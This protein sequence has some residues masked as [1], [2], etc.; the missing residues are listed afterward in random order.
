MPVSPTPTPLPVSPTPTPLLLHGQAS[1]SDINAA[2]KSIA[3]LLHNM[4]LFM[5][6]GTDTAGNPIYELDRPATRIEALAIIIRL[7]GLESAANAYEGANPFTD[8][9]DWADRIAAYAYANGITVGVN[10][11][12]TLFN[13]DA[14]ISYQEFTAFLLRVLGYYEKNGD[15]TFDEAL[16]KAIEAS[17]Y[18]SGEIQ[19]IGG[20]YIYLRA[21]VVIGIADAL[22]TPLNGT[23]IRLID[24]LA[25]D[26]VISRQD[27]NM[28]TATVSQIYVK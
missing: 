8:T 2:A 1:R 28:F 26:G 20:Q 15:F 24:I 19:S 21:D 9:P 16:N 5:G 25:E 14:P 27:V 4:N 23:N 17:L 18:S 10:D 12:H 13:A 3:D 22:M 7:M 6:T 11:D